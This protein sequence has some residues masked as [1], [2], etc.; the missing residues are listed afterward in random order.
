MNNISQE[1]DLCLI[2]GYW[3]EYKPTL[4]ITVNDAHTLEKST[5]ALI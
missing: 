5:K 3:S 1:S 2:D 4:D